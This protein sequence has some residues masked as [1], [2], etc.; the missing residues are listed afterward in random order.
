MGK[1]FYVLAF[2]FGDGED[3]F[4]LNKKAMNRFISLQEEAAKQSF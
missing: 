3:F 4:V 1:E 2:S